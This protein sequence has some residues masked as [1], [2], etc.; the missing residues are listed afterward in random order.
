MD[1]HLRKLQ[2]DASNGDP[3]SVQRYIRALER[4]VGRRSD[5]KKLRSLLNNAKWALR[6]FAALGHEVDLSYLEERC[7]WCLDDEDIIY[8][9]T[10]Y[11]EI[12]EFF[13]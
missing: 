13:S 11:E 10:I 1:S 9:H 4:I 12:K 3:E 5:P 8:A 6:P 2:R 7:D